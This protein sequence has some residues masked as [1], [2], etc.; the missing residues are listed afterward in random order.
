MRY[1]LI[2][3]IILLRV[4]STNPARAAGPQPV[5][6]PLRAGTFLVSSPG[7]IDPNFFHTVIFLVSYGSEGAAGLIINRPTDVPPEKAL[8]DVEGIE[9]LTN[10]VYFGGPVGPEVLR[11]ILRSEAPLEGAQ[12]ILGDVYVTASRTLLTDAL[13]DQTPGRKVRVYAGYAGWAPGQL[14]GEFARGDWNVKEAVPDAVF[15]E[16]PSTI[17]TSF[18][19]GGEEIQI[20]FPGPEGPVLFPGPQKWVRISAETEAGIRPNSLLTSPAA[21]DFPDGIEIPKAS[22]VSFDTEKIE[23]KAK[24]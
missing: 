20:R 15:S 4:I 8:P 5:G 1:I 18:I 19:E 12:K 23:L 6:E 14:D 13:R 21:G 17:W 16:D 24:R 22:S 11:V 7:L 2:T 9:K 3:L 10:P